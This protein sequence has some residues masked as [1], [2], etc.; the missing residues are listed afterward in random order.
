M[1]REPDAMALSAL[2]QIVTSLF[3]NGG[4]ELS[5]GALKSGFREAVKRD[6]LDSLAAVVIGG[7]YLFYLAEKGKNPKVTSFY[8]ALVFITTCA[9]V[10]YSDI[11]AR[12]DSGKA[13]AAFVMTFGPSLS[14]SALDAPAGEKPEPTVTVSPES[15]EVQKAILAKLEAIH[16]QLAA[17]AAQAR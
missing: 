14:A 12:T 15:L 13:I 9:S 1:K 3:A 4:G 16:G 17:G 5:F 10:G 6:P 7:S 2:G 8:D 11:F